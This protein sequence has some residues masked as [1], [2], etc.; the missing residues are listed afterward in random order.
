[1]I[2]LRLARFNVKRIIRHRGLKWALVLLPLVVALVRAVFAGSGVVLIAAELC[3][4]ACALLIAAVLYAQWSVDCVSGLVTGLVAGP[5][6]PRAIVI[7][8]VLSGL[9]IL[10]IQMALF[11]AILTARF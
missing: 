5:V 2:V 7:S 9:C 11:G 6:P 8:R 3:P 10:A 1:M 4:V